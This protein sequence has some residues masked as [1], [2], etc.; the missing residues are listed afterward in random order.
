MLPPDD[1]INLNYRRHSRLTAALI[2]ITPVQSVDDLGI[3]VD[4][5]LSA[6]ERRPT[7]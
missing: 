5:D 2:F 4:D 6:D 7:T 3:Y 1:S